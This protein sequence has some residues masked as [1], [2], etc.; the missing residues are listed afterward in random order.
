MKCPVCIGSAVDITLSDFNVKWFRSSECVEYCNWRNVESKYLQHNIYFLNIFQGKQF[1]MSTL[2]YVCRF[3]SHQ[4][5]VWNWLI[6]SLKNLNFQMNLSPDILF[7]LSPDELLQNIDSR[8]VSVPP[9]GCGQTK[10]HRETWVHF[11]FCA[12]SQVLLFSLIHFESNWAISLTWFLSLREGN[13]SQLALRLLKQFHRMLRKLMPNFSGQS[14]LA[15]FLF[16]SISTPIHE[17][18]W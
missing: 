17:R 18:H 7:A 4:A 14:E 12:L 16:Q 10:Q 2:L 5:D 13:R 15:F 8:K 11:V 3:P 9:R 6:L 1:A